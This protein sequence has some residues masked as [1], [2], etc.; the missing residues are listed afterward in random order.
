MTTQTFDFQ[1][2][3]PDTILDAIESTDIRVDSGLL[4]LNSYENRVYQ[5]LD[6]DRRRYVV[7]FYRPERWSELQILEEHALAFELA[8]QEI[9]V[10]APLKFDNQ[11]LLNY[12]GWLFAI[13]PSVG[14]RQ[15]EVDNLDHLEWVGRFIG[16]IHAATKN[17]LFEHRPSISYHEFVEQ[18]LALLQKS[19][20]V[21]MSLET[22]FFTIFEQL[23]DAIKPLYHS[24]SN[25]RL[26][27]DCHPGNILWNDGPQFVDLD[28]ARNGPAIQD[29]WMMLS[30]DRN[31]QL[32]QL[33]ILVEGY[34]EFHSF[35][36]SQLKLI[37]PLRGMRMLHYMAWLAKR[38]QDP[39][40]QRTF[41]WF[42]EEKYWENQILAMK[43][44]YAA[45]DEE[46]IKLI[47]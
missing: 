1:Q 44:Q 19:Q 10:V 8:A 2:L 32:L 18:P 9:P 46:P 3:H 5:F 11:S 14:G 39:A 20:F 36:H 16:R 7:K 31:Q 43:E 42:A 15:F 35:D 24:D 34:E 29:I 4:P 6:E 30:G 23:A 45:L 38:W 28:D 13:F 47:L 41:A 25:M 33:D 37:E 12:H 17:S 40:F 26:H 27:G 21:P 22:A